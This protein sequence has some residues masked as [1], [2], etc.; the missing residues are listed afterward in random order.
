MLTMFKVET[1]CIL[2]TFPFNYPPCT[3][4]LLANGITLGAF[5]SHLPLRTSNATESNRMRWVT[6]PDVARPT[7]RE[8]DG[9]PGP[10]TGKETQ[11]EKC[12]I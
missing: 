7:A 5:L 8:A 4:E 11:K 3:F 2:S 6:A 9:N 10:E 1:R 12:I